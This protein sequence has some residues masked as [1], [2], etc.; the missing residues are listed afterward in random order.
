[1]TVPNTTGPLVTASQD[2]DLR[3]LQPIL[4][5]PSGLSAISSAT[6]SSPESRKRG[7]ETENVEEPNNKKSKTEQLDE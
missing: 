5:T 6:E 4:S 3:V 7:T 2:V 1:M